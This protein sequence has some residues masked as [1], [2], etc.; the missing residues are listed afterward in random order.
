MLVRCRMLRQDR[1]GRRRTVTRAC[2]S[3]RSRSWNRCGAARKQRLLLEP[4]RRPLRG[5]LAN[6]KRVRGSAVGCCATGT[7][8]DPQCPLCVELPKRFPPVVPCPQIVWTGKRRAPCRL[9]AGHP[10]LCK[11]SSRVVEEKPDTRDG[12]PKLA[13]ERKRGNL[14]FQR[15]LRLGPHR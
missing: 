1:R 11:P 6:A 5:P 7:C 2:V 3:S 8:T 9:V 14:A 15:R 13:G 4:L 10:G 12:A